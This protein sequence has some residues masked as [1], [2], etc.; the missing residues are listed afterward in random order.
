MENM[1]NSDLSS[2]WDG[3]IES[4]LTVGFFSM[5]LDSNIPGKQHINSKATEHG[6]RRVTC[7]FLPLQNRISK[8]PIGSM[9]SNEEERNEYLVKQYKE[10]INFMQKNNQVC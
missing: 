9:T 2:L 1:N 3:R 10:R 5:I 8:H 4:L 6:P 7:Y